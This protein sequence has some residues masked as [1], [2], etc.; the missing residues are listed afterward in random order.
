MPTH[1]E[2]EYDAF[3][4][5]AAIDDPWVAELLHDLRQLDP[6]L[7]IWVDHEKTEP[8]V[9]LL[10][11]IDEALRSSRHTLVAISKRALQESN[12]LQEEISRAH[13]QSIRTQYQQKIIPLLVDTPCPSSLSGVGYIDFRDTGKRPQSLK[14]LV[15]AIRQIGTP[16]TVPI[17][18]QK[19]AQ[20]LAEIISSA[21]SKLLIMGH[22][23]D[24]LS[25]DRNVK[26]SLIDRITRGVHVTILILNP[27]SKYAEA[28]EPFHLMESTRPA[29]Q[30]AEDTLDFLGSLFNNILDE[31]QKQQLDVFLTNWM[32]RFRAILVDDR[33]CYLTLYTYGQDVTPSSDLIFSVDDQSTH[34]HWFHRVSESMDRL[35]SSPDS[36]PFI[37]DGYL[38][39][40][41]RD[42][43]L[44]TS[45]QW[46]Q[47]SR[48]RFLTTYLYYTQHARAFVDRFD[49]LEVEVQRHLDGFAGN[50]IVLGCGAG[51][52]V[53]YLWKN[54]RVDN[55]IGLDLSPDCIV[56][57]R[58]LGATLRNDC[59]LDISLQQVKVSFRIA[60]FYDLR[61]HTSRGGA[62]GIVANAAFVHLVQR[63]D[64]VHLLQ[65][66]HEALKPGGQFFLRLLDRPE[67]PERQHY[68]ASRDRF[69]SERWF[70]YFSP[71]EVRTAAKKQGFIIDE[72]LTDQIAKERSLSVPTVK[73]QGFP[74]QEFAGVYW[75]TFLLRKPGAKG[76]RQ[77]I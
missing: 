54:Q 37:R 25:N 4:S 1:T 50:V 9:L 34:S 24:R 75:P 10:P 42:C 62:D 40:Y 36:F 7:K 31:T 65:L 58:S 63:S 43:H 49:S 52:E 28:H 17:R 45:W 46:P 21:S 67:I 48:K 64:F 76:A 61:F 60:D 38:Y 5:H 8:G 56:R 55:V 73:T 47:E 53:R 71:E 22:T 59:N 3:L 18:A 16:L 29:N 26:S 35:L 69:Y 77:E 66:V 32:P 20:P 72:V 11:Q 13:L 39:S 57:A 19:P 44:A 12:W 70:V 68:H 14:A 74:H 30:Q 27:N 23:L 51:K 2:Y 33:S 6:N 15:N 41:W